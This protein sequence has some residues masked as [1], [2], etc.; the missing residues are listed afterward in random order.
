MRCSPRAVRRRRRWRCSTSRRPATTSCPARRLYGGTYNLFHYSLPKLGIE[1]S[2]VD[3]PD[4]LDAWRA[5]VRPNTKAF[6]AETISNPQ[7]D[8]L[9]IE[10]VAQVAHEAGVPLVVDNTV[11]DPV[12]DPADR[13]GRRHRRALGHQ[14]PRRPRH[15]DRRRDRRRRHASTTPLSRTGSPA[16]TSP[17]PATTA[18]ST[19]GTSASARPL[20]AN[21]SFILKARVQ[22]LRD[23]GPA[24]RA[25]Q[26]VPDRAGHRD[27]EPAGAAA[28]R[29]RTG[30]GH[31]AR[32]PRRGAR[33]SATPGSSPARGT[34]AADKYVAARCRRRAGVRDRGRR[35]GRASDS[36]RRWSCTATWRTS[37]TSAAW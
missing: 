30:R 18:W 9:D 28:Q 32:G 10:A 21:L 8:V 22:L 14:V 31:V 12:P 36:S 7:I 20:G 26:R 4:D 23:L 29:Q 17:T 25:V 1:V 13:V 2:F 19:R 16:S 24:D 27:P 35:R 11:A 3:D 5:A 37:A 15:R 33:A 34:R 6:F